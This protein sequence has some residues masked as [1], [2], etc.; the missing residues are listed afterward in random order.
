[1]GRE[2]LIEHAFD[3]PG[4]EAHRAVSEMFAAR[5]REQWQQ[6]A[7]QHDCC[8]EP[9]LELEEALESELVAAREMVVELAQPGA[10]APVKAARDAGQAEPHAG[11]PTRAPGP[12]LGEHTDEVLSEA[13]YS[14]EEIAALHEAG[15]VAGPAGAVPARSC[16]DRDER[17]GERHAQDVASWRSGRA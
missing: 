9:V 3:P 17:A 13:G 7:S 14:A 10:D 16:A 6:F 4:S 12:G 15:A 2:D 5:T 11:D 8:L 1:M